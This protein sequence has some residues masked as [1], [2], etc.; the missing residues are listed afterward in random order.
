MDYIWHC[1]SEDCRSKGTVL[2]KTNNLI[3][4]DGEIKCSACKRIIKFSEVVTFNK[5]NIELYHD[6]ISKKSTS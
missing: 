5:K 2:F 3:Q 4:H 1:P 6:I